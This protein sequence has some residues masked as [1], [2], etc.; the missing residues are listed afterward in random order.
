[1]AAHSNTRVMPA[2]SA[3][4][5]IAASS[6]ITS[7]FTYESACCSL[8]TPRTTMAIAP[9]TATSTGGIFPEAMRR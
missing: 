9:R 2:I 6:R 3:S 5:I 4:D 7:R 8:M 1:M